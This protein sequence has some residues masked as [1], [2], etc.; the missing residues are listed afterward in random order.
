VGE[1]GLRF[2]Q[3]ADTGVQMTHSVSGLQRRARELDAHVCIV[4]C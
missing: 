1:G 2:S 4:D 3:A